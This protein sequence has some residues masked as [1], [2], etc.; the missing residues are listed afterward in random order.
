MSGGSLT[1]FDGNWI[2]QVMTKKNNIRAPDLA[3]TSYVYGCFRFPFFSNPESQVILWSCLLLDTWKCIVLAK[4]IQIPYVET[5]STALTYLSRLRSI[6]ETR[7]TRS[8]SQVVALRRN[9]RDA[10]PLSGR[11]VGMERR[12]SNILQ[13][14]VFSVNGSFFFHMIDIPSM[15]RDFRGLI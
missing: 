15:C 3:R 12:D 11:R 10:D 6:P 7:L 4:F 5:V 8:S 14:A 2:F 1:F 13:N 9:C